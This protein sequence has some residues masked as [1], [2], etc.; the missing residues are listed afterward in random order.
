M[1]IY[2]STFDEFDYDV[3]RLM[4]FSAKPNSENPLGQFGT[5][6][7]YG[8][9][10]LLRLGCAIQI[11]DRGK[12]IDLSIENR[13]IRGVPT[14]VIKLG[15]ET[16]PFTLALG[17][18][19]TAEDAFRELHSNTLDEDGGTTDSECD[20]PFQIVVTGAP[21]EQAY[22]NRHEIFLSTP[23]TGYGNEVI[24]LHPGATS[25]I[26]Y[27]GVRVYTAQ[28]ADK[29]YAYTY[30]V[31]LGVTLTEDRTLKYTSPVHTAI[32][33]YLVQAAPASVLDTVFQKNNIEFD[34]DYDVGSFRP[35]DAMK[36]WYDENKNRTVVPSS[37]HRLM[38]RKFPERFGKSGK[39][40]TADET[41]RIQTAL[42]IV[43][44]KTGRSISMDSI[45]ILEDSDLAARTWNS[46]EI[47]LGVDVVESSPKKIATVLV[48]VLA[49]QIN[50]FKP[51]TILADWLIYGVK[52]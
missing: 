34:L 6:L 14:E 23:P 4:G 12:V 29:S 26:Y 20:A 31:I 17:K 50:S 36:Q 3:L 43:R 46:S 51:E 8:I 52:K 25:N 7:K 32:A 11:R 35:S 13:V 40:P 37:L 33:E 27:R 30:N 16:L 39:V 5:G 49:E 2:F 41:S 38:M 28:F 18:N 21:I 47:C 15:D 44:A 9:A 45:L 22:A 48:Q 24:K 10:T 19:W 42:D 1:P